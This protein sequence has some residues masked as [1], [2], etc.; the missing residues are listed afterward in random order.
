VR[1]PS[2][3]L[4]A[5]VYD[6]RSAT[7]ASGMSS[8]GRLTLTELNAA[9]K[10][11]A[12]SRPE[13]FPGL[14][15]SE[16]RHGHWVQARESG[17]VGRV[18]LEYVDGPV[19]VLW[20]EEPEGDP[21]AQKM[22]GLCDADELLFLADRT[23]SPWYPRVPSPRSSVAALLAAAG[24]KP[25][26]VVA[27]GEPVPEDSPGVYLISLSEDPND[28]SSNLA[29]PPIGEE[30]I[31]HLLAICDQ[32][33]LDG[34]RPTPS[35]LKERIARMW[36]GAQTVLYVGRAGTSLRSRVAQYYSTPLGAR[37]P[38]AG[39]WFL[40]LLRNLDQLFVHF[41]ASGDPVESE[42]RIVQAF[43]DAVPPLAVI[44]LRRTLGASF[45][46]LP[47]ANL[48]HPDG[49]RKP[50]GI[51]GATG[52]NRSSPTLARGSP[53]GGPD[54]PSTP[55]ERVTLHDEI[56][57]I[58]IENGDG[59]MTTTEITKAVRQRGIYKKRDGTSNV[60]PFQIH[61]RTK[62]YP[63]LFERDKSRVRRRR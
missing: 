40:K 32:L 28:I 26:G 31:E 63:N 53:R 47:F 7:G 61:G 55:E 48:Q 50:H 22:W 4:R 54:M 11:F 14:P 20:E 49:P 58:L 57:A 9:A 33:R 43:V 59:W 45:S 38:H 21:S 62:S 52:C 16:R 39:G 30:A 27:W 37:S 46:P 60:T 1:L 2:R 12:V 18:A 10:E 44:P 41:A 6:H 29:V 8:C 42:R 15:H 34:R 36:L 25:A 13:S 51:S 56:I 5:T 35:Q 17:N 3:L 24:L 19:V 23:P